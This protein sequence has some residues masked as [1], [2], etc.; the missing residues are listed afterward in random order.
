VAGKPIYPCLK[1]TRLGRVTVHRECTPVSLFAIARIHMKSS[2]RC[3]TSC[4][5]IVLLLTLTYAIGYL[6]NISNP[7]IVRQGCVYGVA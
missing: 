2:I 5:T 7:E 6:N 4:K 1:L 3:E